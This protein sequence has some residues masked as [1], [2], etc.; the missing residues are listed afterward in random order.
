MEFSS[1]KRL[2]PI[3]DDNFSIFENGSAKPP[4]YD[5][6]SPIAHLGSVKRP[7]YEDVPIAQLASA[8]RMRAI[9]KDTSLIHLVA[10]SK[11]LLPMQ[12]K[13]NQQTDE[14]IE[15][16]EQKIKDGEVLKGLLEGKTR[17]MEV[18]CAFMEA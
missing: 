12:D 11:R 2:L 1:G 5:D 13:L 3:Y 14:I 4:I 17:N 8:K 18:A 9:R 7:I 10:A 6:D 15:M 16:L